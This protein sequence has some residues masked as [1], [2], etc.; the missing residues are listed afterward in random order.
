MAQKNYAGAARSFTDPMWRGIALYKN[1]DFK[2]AAAAFGQ[3][4]SLEALYNR[5][6]ALLMYVK[7]DWAIAAYE[8]VISKRPDWSEPQKNL[9]LALAWKEKMK[10]PDD[11][12]GGTGGMLEADEIVFNKRPNKSGGEEQNEEAEG[13]KDATGKDIQAM[14]LRRVQMRPADFL[15]AKF[16]YQ[17]MNQQEGQEN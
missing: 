6:N 13:G 15:R 12:A 14:W 5:G 3:A 8:H 2:E 11:D 1:G 9:A 16:S 4:E 10:S 17:I 7:Y